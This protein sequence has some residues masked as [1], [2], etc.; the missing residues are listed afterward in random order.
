[1][2]QRTAGA[3]THRWIT[4]WNNGDL[5]GLL[6]HFADEVIFT[7]PTAARLIDGCDGVVRGKAALRAYWAHGLS[8]N[9]QLRF[10]LVGLYVGINT[11]VINFRDQTGAL[12]NEVLTFHGPLIVEG[13]ATHLQRH[14]AFDEAVSGE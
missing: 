14:P 3:F 1:M 8:R 13:H 6:E 7:S 12:V 4:L 11:L 10:E 2:D 9:P 5:E